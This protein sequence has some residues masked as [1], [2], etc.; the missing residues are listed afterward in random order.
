MSDGVERWSWQ[1][2]DPETF[3]N[4]DLPLPLTMERVVTL[5]VRVSVTFRAAL[6]TP[7]GRKLDLRDYHPTLHVALGDRVA[8]S[9]WDLVEQDSVKPRRLPGSGSHPEAHAQLTLRISAPLGDAATLRLHL[10]GMIDKDSV[11][12]NC[13]LDALSVDVLARSF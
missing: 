7:A 6:V 10:D 8:E 9:A 1:A 13:G 3:Q 4:A 12:M 2:E 5:V 11:R